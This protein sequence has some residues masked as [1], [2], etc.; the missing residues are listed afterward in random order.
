MGEWRWSP[1]DDLG[2]KPSRVEKC[3]CA[4]DGVRLANTWVQD[5]SGCAISQRFALCGSRERV[6]P[7]TVPDTMWPVAITKRLLDTGADDARDDHESIRHKK[8]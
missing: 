4:H 3:S 7:T 6:L 5:V 8:F 1:L 2:V